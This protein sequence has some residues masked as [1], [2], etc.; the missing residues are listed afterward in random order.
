MSRI[1]FGS[2]FTV[3]MASSVY[4]TASDAQSLDGQPPPPTMQQTSPGGGGTGPTMYNA[5]TYASPY[6]PQGAANAPMQMPPPN[7][8]GPGPM[9][10]GGPPPPPNYYGAPP[11]PAPGA[12]APVPPSN[13]PTEEPRINRSGTL[14]F[15]TSLSSGTASF[16]LSIGNQL[17]LRIWASDIVALQPALV[18]TSSYV[19]STKTT[20]Y[21]INPE[22]EALFAVFRGR[23]NRINLGVGFG[24]DT[25]TIKKTSDTTGT[26]GTSGTGTTSSD[27][28]MTAVYVPF[29]L[30]LE[31]FLAPWFSLQVG[32]A[33]ELMRYTTA[34]SGDVSSYSVLSETSSTKLRLGLM[35]YTY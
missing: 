31:Q 15:G 26:G 19:E 30:Q 33:C 35:F 12:P 13:A 17:S 27:A 32:A 21:Q 2:A 5:P 10:P 22:F 8:I 24:I 1:R 25:A 9:N 7:M 28:S 6:A 18:S 23:T 14:G 20:T 3:I 16:P 29:E 34:S 11:P 4:V